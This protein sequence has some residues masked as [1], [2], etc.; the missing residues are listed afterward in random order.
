MGQRGRPIPP[1]H[2]VCKVNFSLSWTGTGEPPSPPSQVAGSGA[3]GGAWPLKE[4]GPLAWTASGAHRRGKGGR[5]GVRSCRLSGFSLPLSRVSAVPF[6][7]L[8]PGR[9]CCRV[10]SAHS[11][12][13]KIEASRWAEVLAFGLSLGPL[14]KVH[15]VNWKD[16]V[17]VT[18]AGY[19][20]TGLVEKAYSF[21]S[22]DPHS[23]PV[24]R[25]VKDQRPGVP[26]RSIATREDN[27]HTHIHR[28]EN[29]FFSW[30]N[31]HVFLCD[32]R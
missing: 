6:H 13:R 19:S 25:R 32:F 21:I 23:T 28:W 5:H 31:V 16:Q 24:I 20:H 2:P 22:S 4:G 11:T 14:G 26:R 17:F 27:T 12:Y 8:A 15:G 7:A 10:P 1:T 3:E 29:R 9:G 30:G 18:C